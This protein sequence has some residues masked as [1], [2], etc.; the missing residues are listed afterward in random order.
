[1]STGIEFCNRLQAKLEP[2][3][4]TRV[5]VRALLLGSLVCNINVPICVYVTIGQMYVYFY[6]PQCWG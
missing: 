4:N 2:Y 3:S 1:M 5:T 6:G